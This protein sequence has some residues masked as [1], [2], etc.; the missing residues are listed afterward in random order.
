MVLIGESA[1]SLLLWVSLAA[2]GA[3]ATYLVVFLVKEWRAKK[4]W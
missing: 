3:G 4:L 2:V 1:L